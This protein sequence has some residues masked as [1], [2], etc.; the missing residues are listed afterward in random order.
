MI[1]ENGMFF[2][3]DVASLFLVLMVI[4]TGFMYAQA[5]ATFLSRGCRFFLNIPASS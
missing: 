3:T 5:A 1:M 4:G 2:I